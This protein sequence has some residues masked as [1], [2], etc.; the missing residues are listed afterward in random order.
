MAETPLAA[1]RC[2]AEQGPSV[3]P[4][5]GRHGIEAILAAT[6][7]RG[8]A[9]GQSSGFCLL[10]LAWAEGPVLAAG[11][12]ARRPVKGRGKANGHGPGTVIVAAE[13]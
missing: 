1:V 5:R 6:L 9:A 7:R 11:G 12:L 10:A 13:S 4:A 8:P 3:L 2:K